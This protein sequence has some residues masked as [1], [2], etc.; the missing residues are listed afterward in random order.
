MVI[1]FMK[2]LPL[3]RISKPLDTTWRVLKC[4]RLKS[5]PYDHDTHSRSRAIRVRVD[6]GQMRAT[7]DRYAARLPRTRW[8]W[9]N[10]WERRL[11]TPPHHRAEQETAHRL[12]GQ[13]LAGPAHSRR[14]PA[15]PHRFA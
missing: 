10:A 12:A 13:G 15:R 14:P 3:R 6:P 9:R 5:H 1:S 8:F 4:Q 11:E 7:D 2:P